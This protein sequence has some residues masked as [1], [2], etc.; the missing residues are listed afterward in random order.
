MSLVNSTEAT[1]TEFGMA[2]AHDFFKKFSQIAVINDKPALDYVVG[3]KD[4]RIK[5]EDV[6]RSPV[7][8]SPKTNSK[9]NEEASKKAAEVNTDLSIHESCN[10]VS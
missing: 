9:S 3:W 2:L 6:R 7:K 5:D 1:R 4:L 10:D 8:D